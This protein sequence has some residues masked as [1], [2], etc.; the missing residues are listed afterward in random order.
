MKKPVY[1]DDCKKAI[2]INLLF[3]DVFEVK[4]HK[5]VDRYNKADPTAIS[6]LDRAPS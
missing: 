3:S 4:R 6:D 2:K 1:G 5:N